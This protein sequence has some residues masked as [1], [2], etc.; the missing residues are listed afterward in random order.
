MEFTWND[1]NDPKHFH[2]YDTET[3]E[4]KAILNPLTLFQ[5][6]YY[7][8]SDMVYVNGGYDVASLENKFVKII[9]ECKENP[10]D[11]DRFVD[12][13]S[14]I[15][16]HEL[17]IVENFQEFLGE[18][19]QTS[20]EDVENTQELMEHYIESI[21]TDLD[22]NKLKTTMNGLYNEALDMEIR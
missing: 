16:T 9:V 21:N 17:K 19:V 22:K 4:V 1:E 12:E 15:N 14:D 18:N 11:F 5:K 20:L 6:V 13:I 8:D 2:I 10:Y 7:D 3:H